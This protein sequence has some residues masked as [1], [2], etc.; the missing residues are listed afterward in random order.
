M[1]ARVAVR[2]PGDEIELEGCESSDEALAYVRRLSVAVRS[3]IAARRTLLEEIA[4]RNP[5]G[6]AALPQLGRV[7][8]RSAHAL[9]EARWM[10]TVA[11]VPSGAELCTEAFLSWVGIHLDACDALTRA[12]GTHEADHVRTAVRLLKGA[13][14]FAHQFNV[15]RGRL[16]SRLAA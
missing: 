4:L 13:Q 10:V 5:Q 12:A 11:P 9:D 15:V 1:A 16:A 8:E 2:H 3:A 14:P 7:A 6:E